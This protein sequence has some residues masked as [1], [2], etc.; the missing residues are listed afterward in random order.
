MSKTKREREKVVNEV[1]FNIYKNELQ[2]HIASKILIQMLDNYYNDGTTYIN[3]ELTLY[4]GH[5]KKK[6]VVNLYN[7]KHKVDVVVIRKF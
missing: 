4:L 1:K 2:D 6:Y 3:K 5:I 7:K